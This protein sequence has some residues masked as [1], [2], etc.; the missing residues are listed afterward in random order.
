MAPLPGELSG[1]RRSTSAA[2][3]GEILTVLRQLF[4]GDPNA[5]AHA[6]QWVVA[7]IIG[8][9]VHEFSHAWIADRAGDPTPRAMGRVTFNPLAHLDLFGTLALLFV[10]FG[11]GK[12]VPVNPVYFRRPRRDDICVSLAGI[13][14]NLI[15]ATAFGLPVR[16]GLA[17]VYAPTFAV[18]VQLNLI[19]AFFNL[20]P[21]FPLD[22]SH[23]L[24]DLLPAR[25]ARK[26]GEFYTRYGFILLLLLVTL[27]RPVLTILVS[28]P[29]AI[30]SALLLGIPGGFGLW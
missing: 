17:G 23:V 15:T 11:W 24:S 28:L 7:L 13:I 26:L 25:E 29:V 2:R 22:G 20:I 8:I 3:N 10:G 5:A 6:L 4:S 9:T 27:G 14:A 18:I 16:F 12:P 19:L 30:L 21:I 1:H